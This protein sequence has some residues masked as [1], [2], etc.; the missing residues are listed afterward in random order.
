MGQTLIYSER[1]SRIF[2]AR[3]R[4]PFH[5]EDGADHNEDDADNAHIVP[6]RRKE[7]NIEVQRLSPH[8]ISLQSLLCHF[9][10]ANTANTLRKNLERPCRG[11]TG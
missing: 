1:A 9:N 2:M 5:D 10:Y 6:I 8:L 3:P 7:R 4:H 11:T